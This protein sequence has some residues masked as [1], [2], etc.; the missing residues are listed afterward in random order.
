MDAKVDR[1]ELIR[2]TA[3]VCGN[4][5]SA[6]RAVTQLFDETFQ[7]LGLRATQFSL[8]A[9][10][11]FL[12][13]ITITAMA[14]FFT[15]DRTTLTRNLKPLERHGLL[16]IEPGEDKRTREVTLTAQGRQAVADGLPLWEKA[17]ARVVNGLGQERFQSLLSHLSEVSALAREP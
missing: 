13:S 9:A 17:Q 5:R 6:T 10:I 15:M 14:E 8:L 7:P 3:C 12:G 2:V 1:S 11:E 16:T 4:L